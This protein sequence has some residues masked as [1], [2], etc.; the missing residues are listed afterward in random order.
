MSEECPACLLGGACCLLGCVCCCLLLTLRANMRLNGELARTLLA[1]LQP[2]AVVHG[3]RAGGEVLR[4]EEAV[5]SAGDAGRPDLQAVAYRGPLFGRPTVRLALLLRNCF[6][7][8]ARR[9]GG[10]GACAARS[11]FSYPSRALIQPP[12]A[13]RLNRPPR[14]AHSLDTAAPPRRSTRTQCPA[15]R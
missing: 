5:A 12:R 3:D 9:R 10:V 11:A 14:S 4:R 15:E 1:I 7:A 2:I 8:A 13:A 6:A